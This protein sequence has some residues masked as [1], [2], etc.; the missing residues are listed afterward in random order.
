MIALN[1]SKVFKRPLK[2][3]IR[4]CPKLCET[5]SKH[6][7]QMCKCVEGGDTVSNPKPQ[8]DLL[9]SSTL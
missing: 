5:N 1:T 6:Q 8:R 3:C 7:P 4:D 9:R 2:P